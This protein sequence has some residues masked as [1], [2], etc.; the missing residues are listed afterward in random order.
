MRQFF[1]KPPIKEDDR[2]QKSFESTA[3]FS[4][5]IRANY[6]KNLSSE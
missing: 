1:A 4:M 6:D 2:R 3:T 5:E